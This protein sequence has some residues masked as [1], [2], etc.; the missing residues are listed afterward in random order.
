VLI[1][2]SFHLAF[3]RLLA[4]SVS[5]MGPNVDRIVVVVVV[6]GRLDRSSAAEEAN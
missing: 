5:A 1:F 6:D 4:F 3:V 2:S